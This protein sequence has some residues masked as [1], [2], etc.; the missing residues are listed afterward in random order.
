MLVHAGHSLHNGHYYSFVRAGNGMW[1]L[2]DDSRVA[3]VAE[4][5]VLGQQA[6][7]LF[8]VRRH[9][10]LGV[11]VATAQAAVASALVDTAGA[12]PSGLHVHAPVQAAHLKK[13][14]LL[15]SDSPVVPGPSSSGATHAV[16]SSR[17]AVRAAE[18][19]VLPAALDLGHLQPP[20]WVGGSGVSSP[21]QRT[22]RT[23]PQVHLLLG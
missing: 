15:G 6:Y 5:A 10:R 22:V 18:H 8:Y 2:C 11:S 4:R 20:R 14:V 1:H 19:L 23:K 13:A 7:I 17:M 21:W 12:G 9:P 3:Q 16:S